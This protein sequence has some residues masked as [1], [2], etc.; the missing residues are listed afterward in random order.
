MLALACVQ[1]F[2]CALQPLLT[3]RSQGPEERD[4]TPLLSFGHAPRL[5]PDEDKPLKRSR[6]GFEYA[7]HGLL[8]DNIRLLTEKGTR[9]VARQVPLALHNHGKLTYGKING[10]AGDFYGTAD[11]ISDGKSVV[12]R[13]NRFLAA[14]STFAVDTTR[15]PKEM[16][17]ILDVLSKEVKAVNDA[18]EKGIDPSEAYSK[19]PD[20]TA[21]LQN[22]TITRSGPS[23][24]ELAQVNWDH[25]GGDAQTAYFAGHS[26]ALETAKK[27]L[28][29][30]Y[31]QNAFADHFLED[32]FAAGHVRTPR[33]ELHGKANVF[34]D[35]CAKIMHDEDNAIGLDVSNLNGDQWRMFGD[36]RLFDKVSKQNLDLCKLAVQASADEIW[37]VW[38]TKVVPDVS[39]YK[40]REFWPDLKVA[41]S[42]GGQELAALFPFS[43]GTRRA[44][45]LDRRTH[46]W[47]KYW[48]AAGTYD[49][50]IRSG[51]WTYPIT[52]DGPP[53]VREKGKEGRGE[54]RQQTERSCAVEGEDKVTTA[55]RVSV[56]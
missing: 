10:L 24:L 8:G 49:E 17:E 1:L 40:A 41:R 19:L 51:W 42:E 53:R 16:N 50:A 15:Q 33:R 11:P 28:Y 46:A 31:A 32:L 12:D 3:V 45:L 25:F 30:A 7:E 48:T 20:V 26:Q 9:I 54:H 27:D 2:L 43:N 22:I 52:I 13:Q 37:S 5:V 35:L 34:Y 55:T 56:S 47:T 38:K 23:Y 44:K 18:I 29:L 21:K 4:D 39:E 14:W 6:Y 36:K